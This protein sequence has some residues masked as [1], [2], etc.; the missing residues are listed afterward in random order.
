M[1]I[2]IVLV[3][4]ML[5]FEFYYYARARFVCRK[6]Q[7]GKNYIVCYLDDKK[8]K[9]W[10]TYNSLVACRSKKFNGY[11]FL[12]LESHG[13]VQMVEMDKIRRIREVSKMMEIVIGN[14]I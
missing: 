11:E 1:I 4:L 7:T 6:M 8:I 13:V 10:I 12:E 5:V 3:V 2:G 14:L 9:G